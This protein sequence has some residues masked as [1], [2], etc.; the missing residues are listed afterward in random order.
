MLNENVT[1]VAAKRAGVRLD[2]SINK[3]LSTAI[4]TNTSSHAGGIRLWRRVTAFN[5]NLERY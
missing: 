4:D 2:P 5:I 1:N 3:L